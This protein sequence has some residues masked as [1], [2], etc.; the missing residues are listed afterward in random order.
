MMSHVT[1]HGGR[2]G[3]GVSLLV[4]AMTGLGHSA[5]LAQE[6][7]GAPAPDRPVIAALPA[8]GAR[9]LLP[10]DVVELRS[11]TEPEIAGEYS[12]DEDGRVMLPLLGTRVAT[13]RSSD[14][15][16]RHILDEYRGYFREA[17]TVQ[18]VVKRRVRILG[19]VTEP[20]LYLLDPT[21]TLGDALALAGGI[22]ESGD[23]EKI[24]I[25]RDDGPV[26]ETTL[27]RDTPIVQELRSGDQI[28]VPERSWISRH[29]SILVGGVVSGLV[30]IV[31]R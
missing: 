5:L 1:R 2:T 12:V 11:W 24:R 30:F 20:G 6:T 13:D 9:T 4:A 18:V 15:L 27:E 10:G 17:E 25:I 22:T 28:L 3:L 21:M 14:E 7:T 29:S 19:H 26:V 31:S 8:T 16:R 23:E